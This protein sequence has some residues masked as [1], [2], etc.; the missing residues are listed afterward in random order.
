MTTRGRK[1]HKLSFLARRQ[2]TFLGDLQHGL[3]S[4]SKKKHVFTFHQKYIHIMEIGRRPP[5]KQRLGL[6]GNALC[7][8]I[9]MMRLQRLH[10]YP[11]ERYVLV[12]AL[13]CR[14]D[15]HQYCASLGRSFWRKA[16]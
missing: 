7:G 10:F 3:A 9:A 5:T 14:K 13:V 4:I 1:L 16:P 2:D 11:F 8:Y 15:A 6:I 12:H